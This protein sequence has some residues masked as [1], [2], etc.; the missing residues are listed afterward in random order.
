MVLVLVALQPS[1]YAIGHRRHDDLDHDL[2]EPVERDHGEQSLAGPDAGER[3]RI[4]DDAVDTLADR[5]LPPDFG[6]IEVTNVAWLEQLSG[7]VRAADI[8][9]I[10][11]AVLSVVLVAAGIW[12]IDRRKRAVFWMTAAI[13]VLLLIVGLIAGYVGGPLAADVAA[14]KNLALIQAFASELAGSL[15]AWLGACAVGVAV[16]GLA[17]LFV[18]KDRTV[19]E[20]AS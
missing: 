15:M 5:A 7:V 8:A 12:A 18:V 9:V 11:L 1:D 16:I 20:A 19:Q 4:E 3:N 17:L 13:L 6:E 2:E 14:S 10:A